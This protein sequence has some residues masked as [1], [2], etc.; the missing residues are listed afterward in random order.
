[1]DET[2]VNVHHTNQY[3][4]I[5]NDGKGGWKVPSGKGQSLIEVHAG[6]ADGWVQSADLVFRSKTNS[7]VYQHEMNTEYFIDWITL[8]LL[9]NIPP[10]SVVLDNDH[11]K[12][13][14]TAPTTAT[15]KNNRNG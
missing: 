4:W 3:I 15:K 10:N 1:M 5:D 8:Q 9:L 12:Q 6:N 2:W 13:K 7:A 14:D 11:N